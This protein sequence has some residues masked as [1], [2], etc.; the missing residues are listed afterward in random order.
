MH[1][2]RKLIIW[3]LAIELAEEVYKTITEMPSS[4]KYNLIS[5]MSRAVISI[6]SNIAE[7][8]GRN[9]KGEF[10]Q[11][12]GIALGS[13]YELETQVILS[14]RLNYLSVKDSEKICSKI[15]LLQKKIYKFRQSLR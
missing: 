12:L 3:E 8:A 9:S 2:F 4:E 14:Q 1:N 7:G 6:P 13:S 10:R 5:Q 11:F 15:T